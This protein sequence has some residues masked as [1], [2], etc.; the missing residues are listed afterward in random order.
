MCTTI[1]PI[2]YKVTTRFIIAATLRDY[3]GRT[4]VTREIFNNVLNIV[5]DTV[6]KQCRG[7]YTRTRSLGTFTQTCVYNV[8]NDEEPIYC[9]E[10]V[11]YVRDGEVKDNEI[12]LNIEK[13]VCLKVLEPANN[14]VIHGDT[15]L[16]K[17]IVNVIKY[18]SGCHIEPQIEVKHVSALM[19]EKYL[20]ELR[21][22]GVEEAT[23]ATITV[24][25]G[26]RDRLKMVEKALRM[27]PGVS[28][29]GSDKTVNIRANIVE[30]RHVV[31]AEVDVQTLL[32]SLSRV[33]KNDA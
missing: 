16:A 8:E 29:I 11:A 27:L 32:D 2:V 5:I 20:V 23:T 18:L 6:R 15:T 12:V 19:Q 28:M 10:Y 4:E 1:K 3:T 31:R 33:L 21:I 24:D 7:C 14:I 17:F 13:S 30:I 22:R 25:I 9:I 26:S